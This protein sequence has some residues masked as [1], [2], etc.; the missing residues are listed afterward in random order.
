VPNSEFLNQVSGVRI[1]PALPLADGI[2]CAESAADREFVL[3]LHVRAT[4]NESPVV[5]TFRPHHFCVGSRWI[6]FVIEDHRFGNA[7]R[8]LQRFGSPALTAWWM[9]DQSFEL[10]IEKLA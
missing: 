6:K 1:S 10:F 3:K 2:H 7:A 9:S 8:V 5:V 4:D